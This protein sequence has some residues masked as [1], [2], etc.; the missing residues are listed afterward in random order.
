MNHA[1]ALFQRQ[2]SEAI[3]LSERTQE[4][5]LNPAPKVNAPWLAHYTAILALDHTSHSI[6]HHTVLN[7]CTYTPAPPNASPIPLKEL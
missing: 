2:L 6:T 7:G 4:P 3:T 5:Q 1:D